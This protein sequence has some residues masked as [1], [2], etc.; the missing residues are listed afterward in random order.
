MTAQSSAPVHCTKSIII[1][2]IMVQDCTT[3]YSLFF[4]PTAIC[5]MDEIFVWMS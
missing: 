5:L 1:M 4:P 3:Y 2:Y